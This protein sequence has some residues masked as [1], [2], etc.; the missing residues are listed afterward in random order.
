MFSLFSLTER[1]GILLRRR[2]PASHRPASPVQGPVDRQAEIGP[3]PGQTYPSGH[4]YPFQHPY[5]CHRNLAWVRRCRTTDPSSP[6]CLVVVA[7][8]VDSGSG[9]E[10][11]YRNGLHLANSQESASC[12]EKVIAVVEVADRP[13]SA[14]V[15]DAVEDS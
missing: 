1:P 4:P 2:Q 11:D 15:D 12:G 14:V 9:C 6:A 13:T 10:Q 3:G 7:V 8:D 5:P